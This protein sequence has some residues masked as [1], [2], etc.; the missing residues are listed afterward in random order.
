L[1]EKWLLGII[2]NKV[3]E[4]KQANIK[5]AREMTEEAARAGARVVV[6]PEM[7]NCPYSSKFFPSFAEE[8]PG[9]ETMSMLSETARTEKIYLFGGS[10]PEKENGRIY[11]TCFVFG[12]DGQLLAR[13]RKAHLYDVELSDG[14]C[15]RESDTL[16]RGDTITVVDTAFGKIGVGICYDI[17]FPEMVRAVSLRGATLMVIPAAFNM[18]TGPAHWEL[19]FRMRAIDNQIYMAGAAPARNEEASYVAYGHSIVTDPWGK[20]V[21]SL[22][23]KEGILVTEIDLLRL[24]QVRKEFPLLKHRR[25]DLYELKEMDKNQ[26]NN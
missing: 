15:F 7:F 1:S 22:D 24:Q 26:S 6:L 8:Y 18:I 5:R 9:G 3:L 25:T 2:Q 14:L 19:T 12:P 17:R 23:E 11:N 20:V 4:N 10:V 13:H 16:G 21:G